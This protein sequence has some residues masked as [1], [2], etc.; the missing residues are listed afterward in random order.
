MRFS[1]SPWGFFTPA[2][3]KASG[4]IR[5]G[6]MSSF[7]AFFFCFFS[8]L[9]IT[10]VRSSSG[11]SCEFPAIFNFGDSSS[12]TGGI[13]VSFPFMTLAEELPYG[14]TFFHKPVS[15]Y[16]DGRLLIDFLG[17]SLKKKKKKKK[18]SNS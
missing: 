5:S 16:S 9:L 13:H 8:C 14:E 12:D 2:Q 18:Y 7:S 10:V 6:L 1:S 11:G 3:G 15:R 17:N 4:G